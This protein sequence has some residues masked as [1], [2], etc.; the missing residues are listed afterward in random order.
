MA[1]VGLAC[2]LAG[3]G[4]DSAESVTPGAPPSPSGT[5]GIAVPGTPRT[6]DP[7]L[8]SELGDRLVAAQIYEPLTRRLSG[9]YGETVRKLGT[10]SGAP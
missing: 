7:L 9:P 2:A 10:G 3:C 4:G 5:L 8:A 6:F 1:L